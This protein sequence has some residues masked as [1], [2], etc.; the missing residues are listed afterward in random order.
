MSSRESNEEL[1]RVAEELR[2]P[3]RRGSNNDESAISAFDDIVDELKHRRM[4]ATHWI[5][6]AESDLAILLAEDDSGLSACSNCD[7]IRDLW[8]PINQEG[9]PGAMCADCLGADFDAKI[10]ELPARRPTHS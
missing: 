6:D 9:G 8:Q 4:G 5:L 1:D 10:T 7:E 3:L 2:K